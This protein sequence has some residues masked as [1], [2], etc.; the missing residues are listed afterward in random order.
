MKPLNETLWKRVKI[1]D[2]SESFTITTTSSSVDSIRLI[3]RSSKTIPYVTR[4]NNNN[5]IAQFVSEDN[6]EY[7]SDAAGCI[8][9]GL[10]TQTAFYQPH[11]FITGQNIHIVKSNHL[12]KDFALFYTTILKKQMEAKF[13]WGGNGATLG[14]MKCIE[15]LVPINQDGTQDY[16]YMTE[17]SREKQKELLSRY[18]TYL[19]QQ[20]TRIDFQSIPILEKKK[21][22][23]FLLSDIFSTIKRGK[24]LKKAN[25]IVGQIP[26]VSSTASNNGVDNYIVASSGT[27]VFNNCISLANSGS[28]GV[29]FYEPFSFVASDHITSL[30]RENS[31]KFIYLFL[32]TTIQKQKRNFNFNREI[33]DNRIKKMQIMLPVTENEQPDFEYMEQYAKNMMLKK[34]KQYFCFLERKEQKQ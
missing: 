4:T 23:P 18:K 34:Y 2:D 15:A 8:S 1:F 29:A 28:V 26:Y 13:N 7:G 3:D 5:G 17:Y 6:Y 9:V 20:I 33:N 24:R 32:I 25:Q 19:E 16:E 12:N 30:K 14:R 31:S 27:R 11:R 21:W 10:D 22:L